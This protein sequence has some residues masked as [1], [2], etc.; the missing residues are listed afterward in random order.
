M[1]ARVEETCGACG[2]R[3]LIGSPML[4]LTFPGTVKFRHRCASCAG[5]PVG[6]SM[7]WVPP[8]LD[9]RRAGLLPLD[10]SRE[11]EPGEEG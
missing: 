1:R 5:E 6:E 8:P 2:T 4:R 11:R 7:P 3:I 9:L 10:F